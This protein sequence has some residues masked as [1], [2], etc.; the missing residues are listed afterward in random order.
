M[1][2]TNDIN[3]VMDSESIEQMRWYLYDSVEAVD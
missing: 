3:V 2:I 1:R